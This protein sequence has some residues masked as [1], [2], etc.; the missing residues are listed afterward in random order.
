MHGKFYSSKM[1]DCIVQPGWLIWHCAWI[2]I[3]CSMLW[4]VAAIRKGKTARQLSK[5]CNREH[6]YSIVRSTILWPLYKYDVDMQAIPVD[7]YC[8]MAQYEYKFV[9]GGGCGQYFF[10]LVKLWTAS[11]WHTVSSEWESFEVSIAVYTCI[12]H[13]RVHIYIC[14]HIYMYMPMT[15]IHVHVIPMKFTCTHTI[16]HTMHPGTRACSHACA[17]ICRGPYALL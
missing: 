15:H 2:H 17:T 7:G 9:M 6:Y 14:V 3:P 8:L 16:M 1:F 11:E 5:K 12:V 13:I 4:S 10:A